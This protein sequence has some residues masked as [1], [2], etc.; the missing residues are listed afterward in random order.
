MRPSW[1]KRVVV[2]K[3]KKFEPPAYAGEIK[4]A[5]K[6]GVECPH[7]VDDAGK[8]FLVGRV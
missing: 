5:Q 3:L 1:V 2:A 6:T 7:R 4:S 8:H